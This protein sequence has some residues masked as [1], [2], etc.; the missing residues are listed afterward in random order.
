MSR[1]KKLERSQWSW[2]FYDWANS[3]FATTVMG[4]FFPIIPAVQPVEVLMAVVGI[5]PLA[6]GNVAFNQVFEHGCLGEAVYALV[7]TLDVNSSFK[8]FNRLVVFALI[9]QAEPETQ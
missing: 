8:Q 6:A 9:L 7:N 4:V 3:S 5:F 1:L 2:A